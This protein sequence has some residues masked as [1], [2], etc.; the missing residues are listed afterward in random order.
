[1]ITTGLIFKHT[2]KNQDPAH[3]YEIGEIEKDWSLE[4][5]RFT[6]VVLNDIGTSNYPVANR[7]IKY[8][9]M[10]HYTGTG[11]NAPTVFWGGPFVASQILHLVNDDQELKL[12]QLLKL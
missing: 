1:M 11:F 6:S 9:C 3:Y 7:D 5:I 4:H 2:T 10:L 8:H 12:V